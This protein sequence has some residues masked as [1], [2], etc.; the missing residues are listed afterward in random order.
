MNIY[1]GEG[2]DY[3]VNLQYLYN[4]KL[5]FVVP[6]FARFCCTPSVF[7]SEVFDSVVVD[8]SKVEAM[9][10]TSISTYWE[11]KVPD[12]ARSPSANRLALHMPSFSNFFSMSQVLLT[13]R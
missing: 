7:E 2:F 5:A 4:K 10:S 13:L 6:W 11:E 9:S 3:F 12:H 8:D 1:K